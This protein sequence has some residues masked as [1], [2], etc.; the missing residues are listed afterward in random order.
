M[1]TKFASKQTPLY[2]V[3][4]DGQAYCYIH[5][6]ETH[7]TDTEERYDPETE[8]TVTVETEYYEYD[9]NYFVES[10]D[11]ISK[12]DIQTHP[13]KYLD[14]HPRAKTKDEIIADLQEKVEVLTNGLLELSEMVYQ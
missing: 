13:E 1:R 8:T 2:V 12:T 14:Y 10:E 5:L 7:G 11:F 3:I 4:K 9:Y 6:N